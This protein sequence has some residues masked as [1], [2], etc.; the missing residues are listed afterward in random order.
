MAK[1][2]QIHAQNNRVFFS[3]ELRNII[4]YLGQVGDS[5]LVQFSYCL[6]NSCMRFSKIAGLRKSLIQPVKIPNGAQRLDHRLHCCSDAHWFVL[7]GLVASVSRITYGPPSRGGEAEIY[8]FS[9]KPIS[10]S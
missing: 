10:P 9:H 2:I 1:V 5:K 4:F 3:P 8:V 6:R 7:R